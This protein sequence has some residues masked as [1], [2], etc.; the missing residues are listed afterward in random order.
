MA[1][2]IAAEGSVHLTE[3]PNTTELIAI[4]N[5]NLLHLGIATLLREQEVATTEHNRR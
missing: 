2:S 4:S 1:S 5:N 3:Q